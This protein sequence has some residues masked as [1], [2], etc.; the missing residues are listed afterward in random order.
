LCI[1]ADLVSMEGV[2][3]ETQVE[4]LLQ[5]LQAYRPELLDRPRLIVGTKLDSVEP[6][7][8]A[9][10]EALGHR[11]MSSVTGVGVREVLGELAVLVQEARNVPVVDDTEITIRPEP[12]GTRIEKVGDNEFRLHGRSV[13]RAVALSD[14]N[15]P[16]AL[17]YIDDRLS[18][19]GVPR[20]LA[21][22]GAKE[23]AT[24]HIKEFS[25]EYTPEI[26]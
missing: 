4:V 22:A 19:L 10:W 11:S 14:V 17:N 5:E 8:K 9:A 12:E 6:S 18:G 20:L 13:E 7:T 1:L 23:G 15:S 24:I 16:D 25:F 26:G 21:R 3:P 2:A